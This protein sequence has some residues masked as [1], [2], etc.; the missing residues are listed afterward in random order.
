MR[1]FL[2]ARNTPKTIVGDSCP[3]FSKVSNIV[4]KN[5]KNILVYETMEE[6]A[7]GKIPPFDAYQNQ[8]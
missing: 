8:F 1:H 4:K 6:S 7:G 3:D 5:Q 2:K